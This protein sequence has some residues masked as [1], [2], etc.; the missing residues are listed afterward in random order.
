M[1]GSTPSVRRHTAHLDLNMG[2]IGLINS[3]SLP[4]WLTATEAVTAGQQMA[5]FRSKKITQ[6]ANNGASMLII[7]SDTYTYI[8]IDNRFRLND[9]YRAP[10][11]YLYQASRYLFEMYI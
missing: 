9:M 6:H 5:A 10:P 7:G 3:P 11:L 8:N 4:V 2:G 1:I